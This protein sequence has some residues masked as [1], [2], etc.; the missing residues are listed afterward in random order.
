M[1]PSPSSS[2]NPPFQLFTSLRYDPLLLQSPLNIESWP[3]PTSTPTPSPFYMLPYHRDRL[4]QAATHFSFPAA[5]AAISGVS[6]FQ[7]LLS[8]LSSSIDTQ[9]PTPLRVRI[10]LSHTGTL[11]IESNPVPPV[12][13][14]NLFP[15]HLPP[16]SSISL[17]PTPYISSLTG[18]AL[19]LGPTTFLPSDPS[20]SIPW[21]IIPDP[22]RTTPTPYTSFK[23]TSRSQYNSARERAQIP[24]F[25][26]PQ[27]VL[28][29]SSKNGEIMEGSLTTPF[30]YRDG[31]WAT[32]FESSG[33]Q[34]GTTRRWALEKGICEESTIT[35]NSLTEGEECWISNGV[36]GFTW[37]K[38]QLSP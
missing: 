29:I 9:S 36:R 20:T 10:V 28:L 3:L 6:G 18:G 35:L 16:P 34:I 8:T 11:T 37:G 2:P 25:T 1:S 4:L 26:S 31:K 14:S 27:E 33:G 7:N 30:F 13:L 22:S 15:N 38:I 23:T 17:P 12:P 5:I 24:T 32:P 19:T 21:T